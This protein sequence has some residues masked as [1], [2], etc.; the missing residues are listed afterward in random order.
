MLVL[1]RSRDEQISVE[2]ILEAFRDW[3]KTQE[4]F[5]VA[6]E[7]VLDCPDLLE[8]GQISYWNQLIATATPDL[9]RASGSRNPTTRQRRSEARIA[10]LDR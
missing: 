2:Q 9:G 7:R 1:F 3:L 10:R 6:E 8:L 4:T 5:G